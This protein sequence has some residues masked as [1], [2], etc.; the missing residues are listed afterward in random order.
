MRAQEPPGRTKAQAKGIPRYRRFSDGGLRG[1]VDGNFVKSDG[2]GGVLAL[3]ACVRVPRKGEG[4]S[5]G[6]PTLSS[7][8]G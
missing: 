7:I 2:S 8:F 3:Y 4:P 5:V 6:D 1:E